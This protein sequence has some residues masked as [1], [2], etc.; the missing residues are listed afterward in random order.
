VVDS[1]RE[2]VSIT[3][4]SSRVTV[5]LRIRMTSRE[6]RGLTAV[7]AVLVLLFCLSSAASALA[8]ETGCAESGSSVKICG[9]SRHAD[10]VPITVPQVFPAQWDRA[11]TAS[12]PWLSPP[13]LASQFHAG[14]S[15]FGVWGHPSTILIDQA[16]KVVGRVRGERDW[17][18]DAARRLVESLLKTKQKD[19]SERAPQAMAEMMGSM[20]GGMGGA[21]GMMRGSS[22]QHETPDTTR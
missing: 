14:P 21:G 22:R 11:A 6:F 7:T 16:G 1:L 2:S 8:A 3:D 5:S 19:T 18:T 13:S 4:G 17:D 9:H 15:S 12:L 20:G 10:P